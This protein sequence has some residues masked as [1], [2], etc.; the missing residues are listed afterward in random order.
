MTESSTPNPSAYI[1]GGLGA[2]SVA[3]QTVGGVGLVGSF[4]GL[5]LGALVLIGLGGLGGS[6]CY[7]AVQ[8]WR[9]QDGIALG[10]VTLGALGGA[11]WSATFGAGGGGEQRKIRHLKKNPQRWGAFFQRGGLGGLGLP[12]RSRRPL[13]VRANK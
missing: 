12:L 10:A 3:A 6:A 7:G 2:G 11:G 1:L 4:G 9:T 13:V 8:G 5:G